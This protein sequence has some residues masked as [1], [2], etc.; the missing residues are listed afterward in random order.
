MAILL[1]H[2]RRIILLVTVVY[3]SGT[4]LKRL[5]TGVKYSKIPHISFVLKRLHFQSWTYIYTLYT[6]FMIV[7][8]FTW[9]Q[10]NLFIMS[11]Q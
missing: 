11:F 8:Y 2:L 4:V 6:Y 5:I 10:M 9:N 1:V 7:N 3:L